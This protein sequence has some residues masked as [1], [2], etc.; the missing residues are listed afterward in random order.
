MT[1][2]QTLATADPARFDRL[3]AMLELA[4]RV[5]AERRQERADLVRELNEA[6]RG[7]TNER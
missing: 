5:E 2:A 1:L 6:I 4:E 3:M 7:E